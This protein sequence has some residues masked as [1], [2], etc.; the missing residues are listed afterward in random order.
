MV[1]SVGFEPT[2]H[3]DHIPANRRSHGHNTHERPMLG[4]PC[5]NH[6]A[7]TYRSNHA[8]RAWSVAGNPLTSPAAHPILRRGCEIGYFC[9]AAKTHRTRAAGSQK[10]KPTEGR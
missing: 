7:Q 2:R 5:S 4:N 6:K 9:R 8:A 10:E 3:H 1:P